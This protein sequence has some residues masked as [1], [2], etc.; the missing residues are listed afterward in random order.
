MNGV[1]WHQSALNNPR[2][3]VIGNGRSGEEGSRTHTKVGKTWGGPST[4]SQDSRDRK[5]VTLAQ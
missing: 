1:A 4:C 3:T 2:I 5:A